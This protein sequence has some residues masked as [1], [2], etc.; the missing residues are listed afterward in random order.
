MFS[1][2][3]ELNNFQKIYEAL[4]YLHNSKKKYSQKR[5]EIALGILDESLKSNFKNLLYILD[6][7]LNPLEEGKLLVLV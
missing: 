2:S 5:L 3:Y 7:V 4:L 1:E 6:F